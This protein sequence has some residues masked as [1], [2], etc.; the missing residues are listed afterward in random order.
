MKMMEIKAY[1]AITNRDSA[2]WEDTKSLVADHCMAD[3][4]EYSYNKFRLLLK[5]V[6]V[7]FARVHFCPEINQ[8]MTT[9]ACRMEEL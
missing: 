7:S 3:R 9:T 1:T 8:S 5:S 6:T 4:T 2:K